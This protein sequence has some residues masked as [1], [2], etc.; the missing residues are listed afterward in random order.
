[1]FHVVRGGVDAEEMI[2]SREMEEYW[3]EQIRQRAVRVWTSTWSNYAVNE[4]REEDKTGD[5]SYLR[6]EEG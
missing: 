2:T 3:A 1:M 6:E 4:K 5:V